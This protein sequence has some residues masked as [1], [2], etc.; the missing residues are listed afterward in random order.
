MQSK[1]LTHIWESN[2][3]AVF[4]LSAHWA[5][6]NIVALVRHAERC[7]HSDN[8]CLDGDTGITII[9]K[10]I[11]LK[12]GS[13]FEDFLPTDHAL[14]YNSPLKRTSQTAQFMFNGASISQAWLH[15]NC[16][17]RFLEDIIEHKKEGTNMVLVT[18]S[19]CINSLRT[20]HN[21]KLIPIDAGAD[22]NYSVTIFL[23]ISQV[24][25]K[26]Y[27]LGYVDANDWENILQ[28]KTR[29]AGVTPSAGQHL[30]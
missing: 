24:D 4:N 23:T 12:I 21:K 17:T 6:G 20:L 18:H 2:G 9:G 8:Q 27:V 25:R 22:G 19:T 15:D 14:I 5:Q 16:K 28:G 1:K 7:D 26:A 11:S 10:D 29:V 13:N 3:I 30:L